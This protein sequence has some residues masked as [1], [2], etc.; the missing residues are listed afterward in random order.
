MTM[1]PPLRVAV[2]ARA[3]GQGNGGRER[4]QRMATVWSRRPLALLA[5][6]IRSSVT[7]EPADFPRTGVEVSHTP[8]FGSLT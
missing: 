1:S 2:V 3:R 7:R 8:V 4:S 6:V 5:R